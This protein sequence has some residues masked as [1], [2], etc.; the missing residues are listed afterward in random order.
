MSTTVQTLHYKNAIVNKYKTL[1]TNKSDIE[2]IDNIT[3][4]IQENKTKTINDYALS[5]LNALN[6]SLDLYGINGLITQL[7]YFMCNIR[8]KNLRVCVEQII[9]ELKEKQKIVIA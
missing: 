1:L 5:Y 8:D 6:T 9:K 2:L 7:K 3:T 4:L